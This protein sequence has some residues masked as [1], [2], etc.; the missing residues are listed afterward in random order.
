MKYDEL[1][2]D[3]LSFERAILGFFDAFGIQ[4]GFVSQKFK[5]RAKELAKPG[6]ILKKS[7][8]RKVLEG[9]LP[10]IPAPVATFRQPT[11]L[12]R[13]LL[14]ADVCETLL[15]EEIAEEEELNVDRQIGRAL[16]E[17][18]PVSVG[19]A[20]SVDQSVRSDDSQP[21]RKRRGP[22]RPPKRAGKSNG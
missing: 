22:G 6:A 13:V 9:K 21:V 2:T 16:E 7:S 10:G 11:R 18:V 12:Q 4:K 5:D 19:V 17:A 8:L 20:P 14:L 3:S 15:K 1:L